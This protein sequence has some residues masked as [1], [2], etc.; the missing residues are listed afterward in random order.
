MRLRRYVVATAKLTEA[1]GALAHRERATR[2]PG[3]GRHAAG[4][5]NHGPGSDALHHSGQIGR[6]LKPELAEMI[7]CW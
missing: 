3:F 7:S 2:P 6:R 1:C 4:T 5:A